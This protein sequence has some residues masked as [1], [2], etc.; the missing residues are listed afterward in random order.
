S[1][2]KSLWSFGLASFKKCREAVFY[3]RTTTVSRQE[4]KVLLVEVLRQGVETPKGSGVDSKRVYLMVIID[5]VKG[6]YTRVFCLV[7]CCGGKG[8]Y[9]RGRSG[10]RDMKQGKGT[11]KVQVQMRDESSF[12]LDNVRYVLELRRNLISL[13]TLE[14]GGFTVKMQSAKIKEAVRRISDLVEDQDM[15]QHSAR[16]LFRYRE[17][18]NEAAFAVAVAKKIYAHKSLNFNDTVVCEVIFKWKT[19]LK[20][21]I[22][23]RSDVEYASDKAK[24]NILG[25]EIVRDQ[26]AY[27]NV[28]MLDG[29]D[30]EL[31]TYVH[32]F[33]DFNYAMGRLIDVMGRSIICARS[34]EAMIHHMEALS[35]TKAGYMMFTEALRNNLQTFNKDPCEIERANRNRG[36][37]QLGL[38]AQGHMGC[39]GSEWY[40]SGEGSVREKSVGVM[41]ILAGMA[42][43]EFVR[44]VRAGCRSLGLGQKRSLGFN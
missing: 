38:G 8:L 28:G 9:V 27:T 26:S 39:W 40:Y 31:Q 37:C 42:V 17:D 18:T 35:T 34:W 19:G 32:G 16:K 23:A 43:G 4:I 13:G 29:F 30:R 25:M 14:K 22:D 24:I 36:S 5:K 1:R 15:E 12:V 44:L 10:Q 20:E 33:V 11:C 3:T 6:F 7:Q 41:G 21:E 2:H